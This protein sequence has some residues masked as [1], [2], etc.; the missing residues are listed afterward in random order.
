[1]AVPG[2]TTPT[3]LQSRPSTST[4]DLPSG[5]GS[6]LDLDGSS[7]V[8]VSPQNHEEPGGQVSSTFFH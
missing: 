2:E 1:M 5:S 8:W 3:D 6:R 4:T 7:E